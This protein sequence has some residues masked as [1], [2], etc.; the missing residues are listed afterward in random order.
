MQKILDFGSAMKEKMKRVEIV[1]VLVVLLSLA[2]IAVA[3]CTTAAMSPGRIEL[4]ATEFDFG[5]IP[6]TGP[7]SQ[8]FQVRNGGQ[9][10]LEI[11]GVSTSCGC[12]TAEIDSRSLAPGEATDLVV[13]YDPQAH[14]GATG[15]FMRLVYVRSSD[16][17]TPEAILTIW[18]TVVEP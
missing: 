1:L 9:G 4:S 17:E 8:A 11:A 12:T 13:T 3:A 10:M 5:T 7:V 6:N 16:P 2:L 14:D 15:E 18:V